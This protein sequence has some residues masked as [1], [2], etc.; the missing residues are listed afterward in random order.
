[1]GQS[2][3]ALSFVGLALKVLPTCYLHYSLYDCSSIWF[4][5]S[6][7]GLK[8][9]SKP[10]LPWAVP[11]H[12]P[13]ILPISSLVTSILLLLWLCLSPNVGLLGLRDRLT[14]SVVTLRKPFLSPVPDYILLD[15]DADPR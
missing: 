10:Y 14:L 2:G 12:S 15:T 5:V 3:N 11:Q 13:V 8:F 9:F 4:P 1:M 7:Q 6:Q